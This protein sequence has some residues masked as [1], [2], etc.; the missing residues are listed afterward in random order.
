MWL[1]EWSPPADVKEAR[2]RALV[3][4]DNPAKRPCTDQRADQSCSTAAALEDEDD[5]SMEPVA[6][7]Q[8]EVAED[9]EL[10]VF[11][12]TIHAVTH[13]VLLRGDVFVR[14]SRSEARL[15]LAKAAKSKQEAQAELW[16]RR[17]PFEAARCSRLQSKFWS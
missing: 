11:L 9:W 12:R 1:R 5:E 15:A 16:Q 13:K 2:A 7:D 3:V 10:D 14:V 6:M 17:G 4:V 8:P